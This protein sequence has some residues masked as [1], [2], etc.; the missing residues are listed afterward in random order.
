MLK[1][2]L[3]PVLKNEMALKSAVILNSTLLELPMLQLEQRIK[4][5]L[6]ENPFLEASDGIETDNGEDAQKKKEDETKEEEF[7][8]LVQTFS[9]YDEEY[10][11]SYAEE[12]DEREF[13]QA[14]T[15]TLRDSLH[16][17]AQ[18]YFFSQTEGMVAE[19]I[20][21]NL[22][23]DGF[24]KVDFE[25]VRS[26]FP[27][28]SEKLILRILKT[29]QKFEP[30]G[31]AARDTRET[32]MVQ[33]RSRDL[34]LED[35]YIV[36]RDHYDD[37]VNK[38]YSVIMKKTGI[39]HEQ[40]QEIIEEVRSLNPKPGSSKT[41]ELWENADEGSMSITPDLIVSEVEGKFEVM[42]NNASVPNLFINK[43]FEEIYLS[44]NPDEG[45][46][47]YVK[48][49]IESAKWFINAVY[50]RRETLK[51]VMESIVK[52]QRPFFLFGPDKIKPMILK[53][54]AEDIGM[55]IA[56]VSRATKDKYVDTDFG[57][58][59]IKYFFT[60]RSHTSEGEDVS[61]RVIKERIRD[62]IAIEDKR[63]PLS[64][65]FISD[66]LVEEGYTAARRTVQKYREELGIP[67]A[68][69]RKE[70]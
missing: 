14:Y 65:Q 20:I 19:Y 17:Q 21:D 36:L 56:T 9:D 2:T 13:Q 38:R 51:R 39:E 44:K 27:E 37:L 25:L 29:I 16:E 49:K 69:L 24:F 42:L 61:T 58:F 11:E 68:R 47:G 67:V 63:K 7:R 70:L 57:V 50:Q 30:V 31:I 34:Y 35:T 59:E 6:E 8:E 5:E 45:A 15:K 46:K 41:V 33:L 28:A 23:E 48:K 1:Q 12:T 18:E 26:E 3:K 52:I 32:L 43:K 4:E 53:D 40:M 62:I 64:D 10:S 55:D 22:D 54:V 60:E 66:M